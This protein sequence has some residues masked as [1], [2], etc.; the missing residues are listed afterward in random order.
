MSWQLATVMLVFQKA[1]DTHLDTGKLNVYNHL[2]GCG[3]GG[4]HQQWGL[5]FGLE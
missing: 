5:G 1:S 4:V 2:K 3:N